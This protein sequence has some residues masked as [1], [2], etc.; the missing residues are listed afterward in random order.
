MHLCVVNQAIHCFRWWLF[1][2]WASS[3]YKNQCQ[4]DL[5]EQTSVKFQSQ[6]RSFHSR[7]CIWKSR[8][9]NGGH[10][11]WPRCVNTAIN[12]D[13]TMMWTW[14]M[15]NLT[16]IRME[17]DQLKTHSIAWMKM[18]RMKQGFITGTQTVPDRH[19]NVF[20]YSFIITRYMLQE[21]LTI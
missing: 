7:K 9:Q 10:V 3:H 8:P 2:C 21:I 4:L 17:L 1:T 15:N 18:L 6:F 19:F 16:A 20:L 11:S 14:S 12:A 13:A 5:W